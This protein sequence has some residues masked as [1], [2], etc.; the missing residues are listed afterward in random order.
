MFI[1]PQTSWPD[2]SGY[3]N[4]EEYARGERALRERSTH[5][6]TLHCTGVATPIPAQRG[7]RPNGAHSQGLPILEAGVIPYPCGGV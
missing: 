1:H 7:P 5:A 6:A 2:I 3:Q 4:K